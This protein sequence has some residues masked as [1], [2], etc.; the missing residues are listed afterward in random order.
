MP[1]FPLK[2]SIPEP[3]NEDWNAMTPVDELRRHC[4]TCEKNITDFTHMSDAEMGRVLREN[5]GNLC[6]QFRKDQLDR[7][8]RLEGPRRRNGIRALAAS[9]SML[10]SVPV[11][12]QEVV[13]ERIEQV[14]A[15]NKHQAPSSG[16]ITLKGRV[17]DS[18]EEPLIGVSIL[19]KG[20]RSGT[21]TDID[22]LFSLKVPDNGP[23]TLEFSYTGFVTLEKT[24]ELEALQQM[25]AAGKELIMELEEDVAICFSD[26]VLI[27]VV[28]GGISVSYQKP[29]ILEH[30]MVH[31]IHRI[32]INPRPTGPPKTGDWK[33]Y[34]RDLFARRKARRA[35]RK[36][37]RLARRAAR[38]EFLN[39][40]PSTSPDLADHPKVASFSASPFALK[41][42]PNPFAEQLRI[43][44]NISHEQ[45]LRLR[46]FD[47]YGRQLWERQLSAF[48]GEHQ[49]TLD[50]PI[51]D[52]PSGQ[53]LLQMISEKGQQETIRLIR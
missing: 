1:Y 17:T 21:V 29:S 51:Q 28:A 18:D 2:I 5:G 13:P 44:F 37:A 34:W 39:V 47:L 4:A 23:V 19:I 36:A 46:L 33:D 10:L 38:K 35:E 7:P 52:L 15:T 22:G 40:R 25:R 3:C 32:P 30:L 12:A 14:P 27:G 24:Y 41:A 50:Q 26:H 8:L 48:T 6:G 42:S 20:T 16:G 11:V 45:R 49:L 53:Y 9:V 43:T 31:K